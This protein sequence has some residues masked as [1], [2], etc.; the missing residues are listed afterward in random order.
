[1]VE[2]K[3]AGAAVNLVVDRSFAGFAASAG[4]RVIIERNEMAR[5]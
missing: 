4:L 5:K 3:Q 1:M 2:G